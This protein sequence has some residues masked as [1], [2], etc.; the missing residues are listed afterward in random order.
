MRERIRTVAGLIARKSVVIAGT[1]WL[2]IVLLLLPA[3]GIGLLLS[4][5]QSQIE[6]SLD[7]TTIRGDEMSSNRILAI[8]LRGVI[9]GEP[10]N[11]GAPEPGVVYGYRVADQL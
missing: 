5:L 7:Y 8:P 1:T 3:V 11:A 2:V 4:P 6:Q 9:D 10:A